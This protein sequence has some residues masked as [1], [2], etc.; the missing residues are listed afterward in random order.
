[1]FIFDALIHNNGRYVSRIRYS[2][3]VW[4]LLLVGHDKAF[5]TSKGRPEHLRERKLVLNNRWRAALTALTDDVLAQHLG[6][7]LDKRRL[8]A[9]GKRRDEL[10]ATP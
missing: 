9:L 8:G 2:P 6:D 10:L 3:D 4:Q 5:P 7:V 1:M